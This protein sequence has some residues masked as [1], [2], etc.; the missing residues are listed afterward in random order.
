MGNGGVYFSAVVKRLKWN[1]TSECARNGAYGGLVYFA[2]VVTTI[3][4]SWP[5]F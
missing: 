2:F 4:A 5:I 3:I 1:E